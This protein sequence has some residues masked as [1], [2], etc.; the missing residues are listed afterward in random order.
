MSALGCCSETEVGY[1]IFV[2][3]PTNLINLEIKVKTQ[4][5]GIDLKSFNRTDIIISIILIFIFLILRYTRKNTPFEMRLKA[6][7]AGEWE[8]LAHLM[9]H[10]TS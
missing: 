4:L 3:A 8:D 7:V 5:T 6:L 1:I 9:Q 10:K 2:V